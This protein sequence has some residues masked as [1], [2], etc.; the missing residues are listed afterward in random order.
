[1]KKGA[2]RFTYFTPKYAETCQFYADKLGLIVAHSWDR[3]VDD[4]GSLFEAGMGFIEIL[5]LPAHDEH[6]SPGLDY[7]S[8]QGA[9]MCIQV[10]DVDSLFATY[11][12]RNVPF[13]Q[14]LTLQ[15]WQHKSFSVLDPN[16]VVLF[17]FEEQ[18]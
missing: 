15:E 2:F 14:E 13:Q 6:K 18:F 11:K 16:G 12:A 8:P 7:R 5:H 3:S 17:F 9:F 1:M 4:K 10:W